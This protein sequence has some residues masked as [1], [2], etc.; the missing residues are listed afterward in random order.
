M[1]T[2][3]KISLNSLK[4]PSLQ[5]LLKG[6]N[7]SV[8]KPTV[9][10]NNSKE[11]QTLIDNENDSKKTNFSQMTKIKELKSSSMVAAAF[12]SL[13]SEDNKPIHN[14]KVTF[15]DKRICK[16]DSV[17]ELLAIAEDS[18]LDRQHALKVNVD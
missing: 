18:G 17:S 3:R 1:F 9:V 8:A 11:T 5:I 14:Q 16:A 13:H 4:T 7:Y 2:L 12:A 10:L 6:P 15:N